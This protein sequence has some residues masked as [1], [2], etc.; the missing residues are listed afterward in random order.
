MAKQTGSLI[1]PAVAFGSDKTEAMTIVVSQPSAQKDLNSH[2]DLLLNVEA[3][4]LNPYVQSQVLYTM[5]LYRKVNI[6][7]ARLDEPKLSDA[8]IQKLGEDSN[9]NTQM[10]G[11]DYVVTERKYA[12]FPQK[13]GTATIA[14]LTL[15]AEVISDANPRFN[16]FFNQQ[17]THVQKIASNAVTLDV[18]PAPATIQMAHWL[19]AEE[20]QLKQEWSG[21]TANMKVG[22]PLTR[23]LIVLA[24]GATVG[25]LPELNGPSPDS[26]LKT[27]PD[28]P[29]I[30]EMQKPEGV[31]ALREEKIAMIPSRVGSFTLPAIE[32][33]WFNTHSQKMQLA[34]IPATTLT[35]L[36]APQSNNT[37]APTAAPLAVAPAVPAASSTPTSTQP[38]LSN[39]WLWATLF[40]GLGWLTTL[41]Y[42]LAK[43]PATQTLQATDKPPQATHNAAQLLKQACQS[44]NP[45]LTKQ[46]LLQ[47]GL[48]DYNVHSLGELAMRCDARLRDEIQQLNQ[49][50]YAPDTPQQWQGKRLLQAFNEQ[51]ATQKIQKGSKDDKLEPLYR[52]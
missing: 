25:G 4:P 51:Q 14:P 20:L 6:A 23:T 34:K 43:R 48:A 27:Y 24:K 28:Q 36:A 5:R 12:I 45:Q 40:L 42:L 17:S 10:N 16:G 44:N 18:R 52:L 46:A 37:A 31:Y 9:Y 2:E 19:P 11:V 3:S 8:V 22:E 7:G 50:L 1:V 13:S 33:P 47:W 32:V 35:V 38:L 21:D 49:L 29:T 30:K 15:T 26:Q 39:H 41:I